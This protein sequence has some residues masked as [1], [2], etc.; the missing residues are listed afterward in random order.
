LVGLTLIASAATLSRDL[1]FGVYLAAFICFG[2]YMLYLD[3]ISRTLDGA[4]EINK[5]QPISR[6]KSMAVLPVVLVTVMP[7]IILAVFLLLPKMDLAVLRHVRVSLHLNLPMLHSSRVSNPLLTRSRLGDG[8]LAVNPLAYFGFDE[9]LDLNYRGRLSEQVV[10]KVSCPQGVF[11]RALAFDTYDG[12]RWTMTHPNRTYMRLTSY[13]SAIPLAP[14]P[15]LRLP[16]HVPVMELTQVYQMEADQPNLIPAAAI[17]D[18][19]YF[20]ANKVEVDYYGA[21]RSPVLIEKDMVYTVFSRT[22]QYNLEVLRSAPD[23]IPD[24]EGLSEQRYQECLQLPDN[25]PP[26]VKR[27]ADKIVATGQNRFAQAESIDRYLKQNYRYNFDIPPTANHQDVVSDFLFKRKSGYCEHFASSFVILCRCRHIPARLVTGFTPGEY[28]PFT[29]L[30]EIAMKDAHAWAEVYLP[31]WGWVP[32]DPTPEGAPPGFTGKF[33]RAASAYFFDRLWHSLQLALEQ[34]WV[35]TMLHTA[36]AWFKPLPAVVSWF[37]YFV[38]AI[39]Q[40]LAVTLGLIAILLFMYKFVPY[41]AKTPL[42]LGGRKQPPQPYS[43]QQ[44]L[45]FCQELSKLDIERFPHETA[46]ELRQRIAGS[47]VA[48]PELLDLVDNFLNTY[49]CCRFGA[50]ARQ[51]DLGVLN[52]RIKRC[53]H[54]QKRDIA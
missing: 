48:E 11:S 39:W 37:S 35:K 16:A 31:S 41:W 28:N 54:A 51:K 44:Y 53:L 47:G 24:S 21:L 13:G 25:L 20:P 23:V 18:L 19:I 22:P 27:L 6:P 42:S 10:M 1:S 12:H 29:G 3:C 46:Q 15:S 40:P 43:T 2:I 30:W 26:E 52:D 7:L 34:P 36:A 17:P 4:R 9:E 33:N 14:L 38:I 32:F 8:S 5:T 45:R 50:K 49:A